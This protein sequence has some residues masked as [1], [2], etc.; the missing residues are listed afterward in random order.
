MTEKTRPSKETGGPGETGVSSTEA[1]GAASTG[2]TVIYATFPSLETA[3]ATARRL[4]ERRLAACANIIAGMTSI[5]V[6]DG[7]I[8]EDAEVSMIV[9]TSTAGKEAC[10]AAILEGHSYAVPATVAFEA[11]GGSAAYLA[12]VIEGS[13]GV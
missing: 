4:V 5:Y 7:A 8:Q 2:V 11:T 13:R 6:W 10:V 9:K 1:G 3:R 12:W